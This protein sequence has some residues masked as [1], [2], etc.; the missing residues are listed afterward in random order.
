MLSFMKIDFVKEDVLVI[1]EWNATYILKP[2]LMSLA[3]SIASFGI[4]SPLIVQREGNVVIDG[5][6]RLLLIRGN[7]NLADAIMSEIPV[8]YV[9]CEE[10]D[11]MFLHLQINRARGAAVAKKISHIIRTLKRSRKYS[12]KDFEN[13]LSM[14]SVELELMLDGT[15]IKQRDIKS[16]N[17]SR[18]WVPVEAPPGTID[19]APAIIE[20]PPN[21]DR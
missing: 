11:A 5:S 1:P 16:H 12:I 15:I 2:D 21:A 4:L 6:Q 18:A 20:T 17:Y 8:N 14:K 7:K 13:R 19:K 3:D 10:L 9:D